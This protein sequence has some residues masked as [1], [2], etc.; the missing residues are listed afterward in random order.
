MVL[1]ANPITN[2]IQA[3]DMHRDGPRRR[4]EKL[5]DFVL[6]SDGWFRPVEGRQSVNHCAL[7]AHCDRSQNGQLA[8][9][10]IDDKSTADDN[11]TAVRAAT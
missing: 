1:V 2:R 10:E 4:L 11:Q 7:P 9:T 6:S 8:T 3:I 5:P